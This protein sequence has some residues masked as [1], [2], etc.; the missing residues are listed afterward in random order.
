[1]TRPALKDIVHVQWR[2][3]RSAFN[4][5]KADLTR[6]LADAIV[7]AANPA[8]SGGGGVDGRIHAI[9]GPMLA[10]Y[11]AEIIRERGPLAPGEAVIT[12]GFELQAP[13]VIHT[14]GPVWQGGKSGE[15]ALLG[16]AYRECLAI[17][18]KR[19]LDSIAFPSI[20]TG[21]YG[22]PVEFAV[23]IALAEIKPVLDSGKIEE[24]SLYI[25]NPAAFSIWF[26][27]VCNLFGE[28]KS[29]RKG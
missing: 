17:A 5:L 10:H 13:F 14:V 25:P 8:L 7:N 26:D 27:S 22:F 29:W 15:P 1:M 3:P 12:P 23:P 21:A 2:F 6:S 28:P 20:S 18:R 11:C 9:A 4:L 24:I 16:K 19:G